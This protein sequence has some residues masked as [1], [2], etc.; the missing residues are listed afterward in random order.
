LRFNTIEALEVDQIIVDPKRA[1][2]PSVM[3]ELEQLNMGVNVI[4]FAPRV[5]LFVRNHYER[6]LR[7]HLLQPG[8]CFK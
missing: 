6:K 1:I 2:K 5:I 4:K 8:V 3:I 7:D